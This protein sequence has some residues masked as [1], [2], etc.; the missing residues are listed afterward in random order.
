[1]AETSS[2]RMQDAASA[3]DI[4]P[5]TL[6]LIADIKTLLDQRPPP[7]IEA[8][9]L[10]SQ[11]LHASRAAPSP[12]PAPEQPPQQQPPARQASAPL[13]AR[14]EHM[15]RALQHKFQE[16]PMSLGSRM[17][18]DEKPVESITAFA[19]RAAQRVAQTGDFFNAP[20]AR[21]DFRFDASTKARPVP[22]FSSD[23][24]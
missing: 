18:G 19:G 20:N 10:V 2:S 24:H 9:A 22:N 7:S 17:E 1:M 12:D 11:L 8:L 16:R 15:V 23:R 4:E 6:M 5:K 21:H 13:N 3:I 14:R